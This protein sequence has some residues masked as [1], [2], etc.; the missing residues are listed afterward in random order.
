MAAL[1]PETSEA[2]GTRTA[3]KPNLLAFDPHAACCPVVCQSEQFQSS[4]KGLR[5]SPVYLSARGT[6]RSNYKAAAA[7]QGEVVP[8]PLED[9]T[10]AV[11]AAD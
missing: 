8:E 9:H 1:A 3:S 10:G 2:A 5:V 4:V 7:S 6:F 11:A